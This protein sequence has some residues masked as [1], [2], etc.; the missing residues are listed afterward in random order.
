MSVWKD[1]QMD[2]KMGRQMD[3]WMDKQLLNQVMKWESRVEKERSAN[4]EA[5]GKV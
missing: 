2:R 1:E 5:R 3:R 4:S